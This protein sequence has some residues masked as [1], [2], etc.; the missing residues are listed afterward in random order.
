M[1]LQDDC[2]EL[3]SEKINLM[4]QLN[5]SNND[6]DEMLMGFNEDEVRHLRLQISELTGQLEYLEEEN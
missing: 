3:R 6:N 5:T 2:H 4:E 1:N